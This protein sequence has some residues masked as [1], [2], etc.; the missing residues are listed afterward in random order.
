V[1]PVEPLGAAPTGLERLVGRPL[2]PAEQLRVRAEISRLI[3][4]A[5]GKA[6]RARWAKGQR[7]YR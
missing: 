4:E 6:D 5:V 1:T 7:L 3:L 2:T